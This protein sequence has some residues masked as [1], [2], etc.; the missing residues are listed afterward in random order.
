MVNK[1]WYLDESIINRIQ[2]QYIT[3]KPFKGLY[4]VSMV[5]VGE[6]FVKRLQSELVQD[7]SIKTGIHIIEAGLDSSRLEPLV[8]ALKANSAAQ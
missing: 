1:E 7:P 5:P 6:D 2:L 8:N 3:F 4:V